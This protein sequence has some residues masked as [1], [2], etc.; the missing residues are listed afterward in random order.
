MR[1]DHH[2]RHID[3]GRGQGHKSCRSARKRWSVRKGREPASRWR[4]GERRANIA[5]RDP[6]QQLATDRPRRPDGYGSCSASA[7]K[8][9]PLRLSNE[10]AGVPLSPVVASKEPAGGCGRRTIAVLLHAHGA[11]E[12]PSVVRPCRS[13]MQA[14]CA[15]KGQIAGVVY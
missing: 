11:K 10:E 15:R 14:Y 3:P 9:A 4:E 6:G 1:C 13:E 5:D 2:A 8:R 12:G 7:G